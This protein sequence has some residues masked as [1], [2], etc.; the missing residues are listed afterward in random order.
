MPK[1]KEEKLLMKLNLRPV[2]FR[3][4]VGRSKIDYDPNKETIN[5]RD[6]GYSLESA[7]HILTELLIHPDTRFITRGPFEKNNEWRH[8]HM[9]LDGQKIMFFVT[10]MRPRETIRVLSFRR[11]NIKER[12]IFQQYTGY[13]EPMAE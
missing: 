11:A 7:V 3:L 5:R 13:S 8:E 12:Q 4:I 1:N 10:T 2:E 6:H 9:A